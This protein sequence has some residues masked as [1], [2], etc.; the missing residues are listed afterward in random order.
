[1]EHWW[2]TLQQNDEEDVPAPATGDEGLTLA[3]TGATS[4]VKMRKQVSEQHVALLAHR[5]RERSPLEH[6]AQRAHRRNA[7]DRAAGLAA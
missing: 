4:H 7:Y 2:A 3:S 1:M 6:P 5:R